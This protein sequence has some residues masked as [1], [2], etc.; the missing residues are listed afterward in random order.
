[1]VAAGRQ[2]NEQLLACIRACGWSYDGCA[3]AIRAVAKESGA[4][5][6]SLTD[7]MLPTG[8]VARGPAASRLTCWPRRRHVGSAGRSHSPI[9]GFVQMMS[10]RRSRTIYSGGV[11]RSPTL[12][13]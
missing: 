9:L 1:M 12:S 2:R 8:L 13:P 10:R 6:S 7:R 11:I 5:L 3:H 4:D